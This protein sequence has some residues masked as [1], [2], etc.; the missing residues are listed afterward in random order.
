MKY[1]IK[2]ICT[3]ADVATENNWVI[4]TKAMHEAITKVINP[5]PITG[6]D[7]T[8][9]IG[10]AVVRICE[11]NPSHLEFEGEINSDIPITKEDFVITGVWVG[12]VDAE[13]QQIDGFQERTL[14]IKNTSAELSGLILDPRQAV[15]NPLIKFTELSEVEPVPEEVAKEAIE[16]QTNPTVVETPKEEVAVAIDGLRE[17]AAKVDEPETPEEP[18][19]ATERTPEFQAKPIEES[20][21]PAPEGDVEDTPSGVDDSD[22]PAW[23]KEKSE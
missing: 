20:N 2:G 19:T 9:P 14:L 15:S 3:V 17:N 18:V 1:K 7:M 8:S 10:Q 13:Q 4:T 23:Q 12:D 16:P 6:I 11:S 5:V 22:K 21:P